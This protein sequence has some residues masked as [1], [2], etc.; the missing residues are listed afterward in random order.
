MMQYDGMGMRGAGRAISV[1]SSSPR[2]VIITKND[3]GRV[4]EAAA[5][6]RWQRCR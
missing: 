6:R 4:K 3:A 5:S 1:R 2:P